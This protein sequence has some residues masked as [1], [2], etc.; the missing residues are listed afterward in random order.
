MAGKV[1]SC[2][3]SSV[4]ARDACADGAHGGHF[5]RPRRAEGN[6]ELRHN[7]VRRKLLTT[8]MPRETRSRRRGRWSVSKAITESAAESK[9]RV[10]PCFNGNLIGGSEGGPVSPQVNCYAAQPNAK[11]RT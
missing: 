8:Q 7:V 1:D 10:V 11:L 2:A 3:P 9:A 4:H 6:D 5:S